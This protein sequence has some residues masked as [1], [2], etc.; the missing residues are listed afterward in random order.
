MLKQWVKHRINF[1][2][3]TLTKVEPTFDLC[4]NTEATNANI[5]PSRWGQLWETSFVCST[6][7]DCSSRHIIRGHPADSGS[8][9]LKAVSVPNTW[10]LQAR[11][12]FGNHVAVIKHM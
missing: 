12:K 1:R 9:T 2:D 8:N 7:R 3:T 10:A 11:C 6:P 4:F 5:V